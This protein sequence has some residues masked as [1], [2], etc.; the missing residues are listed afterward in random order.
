MD[1]HSIKGAEKI[2][3]T[4]EKYVSLGISKYTEQLF[5]GK[6][7]RDIHVEILNHEV[8]RFTMPSIVS[9]GVSWR[10]NT[11]MRTFHCH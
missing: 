4:D 1:K 6:R 3:L 2:A 7:K 11:R 8:S 9:V 5:H 10:G